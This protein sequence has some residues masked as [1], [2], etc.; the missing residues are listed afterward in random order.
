MLHT[1]VKSLSDP[2]QPENARR[3]TTMFCC[4]GWIWQGVEAEYT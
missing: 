2:K 4:L 1:D 3:E